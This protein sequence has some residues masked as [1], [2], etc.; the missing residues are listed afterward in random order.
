MKDNKIFNYKFH[1]K[2][3]IIVKRKI[4]QENEQ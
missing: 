3:E 1:Y 4:T 2:A